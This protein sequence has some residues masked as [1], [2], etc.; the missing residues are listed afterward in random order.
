[1]AKVRQLD[2]FV[3]IEHVRV[4]DQF[5]IEDERGNLNDSRALSQMLRTRT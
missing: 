1:M 4:R 2:A 5:D 3:H